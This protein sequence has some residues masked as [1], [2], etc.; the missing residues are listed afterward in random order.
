MLTAEQ[1]LPSAD[2]VKIL[3][4][5]QEMNWP[6]DRAEA[7]VDMAVHAVQQALSRVLNSPRVLPYA[8]DQIQATSMALQLLALHAQGMQESTQQVLTREGVPSRTV[9][10]E[11]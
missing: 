10:T 8:A 6:A 11:A 9:E 3:R 4:E 5:M 2:R 7:I 1:I